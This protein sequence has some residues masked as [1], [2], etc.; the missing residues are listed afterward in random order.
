MSPAPIAA[1]YWV[2]EM[3][4]V[5]HS[6]ARRYQGR[7]KIIVAS[8]SSSLFGVDTRQLGREVGVPA[9]NFGLHAAL[10]L[11][12][13]LAETSLVAERGDAVILALEPHYYCGEGVTEWQARNTIAWDH[14]KWNSWS[15]LERIEAI[16]ALSPTAMVE[17]VAARLGDPK[18]SRSLARRVAALDD[19][20]ILSKFGAAGV[21]DRF[22]YSAY[23]L[24]NLGN[25]L[26]IGGAEF[27]D[28]ARSV[29]A[30]TRICS[31]SLATLETFVRQMEGRG[32]AVRFANS[33]F[34]SN[35][36]YSKKRVGKVSQKFSD[37]IGQIAPVLDSREDV[38]FPRE[39]FFNTDSHLNDQGRKLRTQ[40]L[41][42][43]ILS[44]A[45]LSAHLGL[46]RESVSDAA[47]NSKPPLRSRRASAAHP[48]GTS[49]RS[50]SARRR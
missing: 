2:R 16:G 24:D 21:P 23:H 20:K 22:G 15:T 1:E 50:S 49:A 33:P 10:P 39:Y 35:G 9:I 29:E 42:R 30:E 8:G 47:R 37:A 11:S 13:I 36:E 12:K 31:G 40:R 43:A 7:P 6:I 18:S 28:R 14:E 45:A 44:D 48:R 41:V 4:V 5:K 34:V 26:Q 32:V 19:E 25:M 3:I 27:R 38:M 17:I 46:R